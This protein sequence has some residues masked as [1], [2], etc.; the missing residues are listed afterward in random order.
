[1]NQSRSKQGPRSKRGALFSYAPRA[2]F[3]LVELIVTVA[4]IGILALTAAPH[5]S[6]YTQQARV[7]RSETDLEKI[8]QAFYNHYYDTLIA[9][10]REFPPAPADSV[11]D[12]SWAGTSSLH[13]GASP[14]SLFAEGRI[15]TNPF[16]N[17]YLYI[18]LKNENGKVGGFFLKDPDIG[19]FVSFV[20]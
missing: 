19:T 8:K 6:K 5:Y 20:P 1:M 4:I 13:G 18:V 10:H 15:P 3:T 17:P 2:G 7:T 14:A 16:G 12:A 11:M 9:G